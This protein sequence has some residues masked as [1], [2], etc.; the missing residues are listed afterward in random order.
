[1]RVLLC[2]E[3][4]LF[5]FGVDRVLILYGQQLAN[6]GHSVSAMANSCDEQVVETFADRIITVPSARDY[7]Y[8]NEF[9]AGWLDENWDNLFDAHS[10][11]DVAIVAG[12]P[13][14]AAVP[15][16]RKHGVRVLYN[17]YGVVPLDDYGEGH[18]KVLDR[19]VELRCE[20]IPQCDLVSPISAFIGTSQSGKQAGGVPV[21]TNL[22]GADHMGEKMWDVLEQ[23][24]SLSQVESIIRD[25][26]KARPEASLLINLGRWEPGCYKN[27]Q[28]VMD[29]ATALTAAGRDFAILILADPANAEI[30][31]HYKRNIIP[32]G[33][34]DDAAL[35]MAMASAD[36]GLSVS[37][38]EGFNLPLAEMQW[39]GKPVLCFDVGAH[40][41]VVAHPWFLCR[42][43]NQMIEKASRI[44]AGTGLD[45]SEHEQALHD[46]K[47]T[48]TWSKTVDRLET[49]LEKLTQPGLPEI[50]VDISNAAIDTGNS[51][52]IRVTRSL[53]R[54]LQKY[55]DP[56]FVMWDSELGGYVYPTA[57]E[58]EQLSQFNGPRPRENQIVSPP[59][60][61]F[62][63][64][65]GDL[66]QSDET[67]WLFLS[68]TIMESSGKQI[69]AFARA[70]G[71]RIAA[72]FYDAIPVLRPDLVKDAR[73]R[74][75]HASYMRGLADCDLVIP[76]S[77]FSE[78]CLRKFWDEQLVAPTSVVTTLLP[79]EFDGV[80]RQPINKQVGKKATS[81][82]C[83]STLEPRKNHIRLLDAV[84][85]LRERR[86]DLDFSLTLVGNRYAGGD[87][88]AEAV[89]SACKTD[90]KIKWV[91]V[92]DDEAL[93]S[94]YA[95]SDLTVYASEIEGFGMPILESVW[96]GKP[97]LC[98][99]SGVM[100]E[101]ALGG[102]V[103]T[104][105]MTDTNA[106]SAKL[107][108]L[109]E[110]PSLRRELAIQAIDRKL[111]TWDEYVE[112]VLSALVHW[113][114]ETTGEKMAEEHSLTVADEAITSDWQ[115]FLYKGCL[116]AEWQ[117]NDSERVGLMAV[118]SRLKPRCAIEV[119]TYRG[120]SLSLIAQ[121]AE[122]VYSIDI[123][124]DIPERYKD[125]ANARFFTGPSD[126]VL[127]L[128]LERLDANNIPVDFVLIDGDHS[129][130]G[131]RRDI[132]IMLDYVPKA[133]MIMMMHDGFNPEC[134]RGMVES[135]WNRNP[136]VHYVDLDFI[137]GRIV[138]T[139][140][141]ANGEMWGGLAL[142]YFSP[143][144]RAGD[145][146]V[147]TTSSNAFERALKESAH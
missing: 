86:P 21:E 3:R 115:S 105:D 120:G 23:S 102:G 20:Y 18:R 25:F 111:K 36:L 54:E 125:I 140:G 127:P 63:F 70:R 144:K 116:T 77:E 43:Q 26:R 96:Y 66:E 58:Y 118:L 33:F 81:I 91:G 97:C 104:V 143:V 72:I 99:S 6:R 134:R 131:V 71:F 52:V 112:G 45:K 123:D 122:C 31:D 130:E 17:D 113:R 7:F 65:M 61:R 16:F 79:A 38:W 1:M 95:K 47:A 133:P 145:V 15:V 19:L 106:M 98:H 59:G 27:S 119:G 46:F 68:E 64:E 78:Q 93:A 114:C 138:E 124:P 147:A 135:R 107:E 2:N 75:N 90:S 28:A 141:G 117:M 74:E 13:F 60:R 109:I 11:P 55:C 121:T 40:P 146:R 69:R 39:L 35:Q 4:F 103:A 5:R 48:F 10:K 8:S 82:L 24:N 80:T 14:L 51:G 87:Y 34:P 62:R 32:I 142:A 73:I 94:V 101:L 89:E 100:A 12:W 57:P 83:V 126:K 41:E 92:I 67:P 85:A 9:T 30:P 44:L 42:D 29:I 50:V 53:C 56:V 139:A 37:L 88:I 110:N 129:A 76:I 22:L 136:Y 137:P 49:Q 84:K 132:E 108:E 128:L